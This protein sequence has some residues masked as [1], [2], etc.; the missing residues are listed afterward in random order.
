MAEMSLT[1]ILARLK[2]LKKR[3]PELIKNSTTIQLTKGEG[4]KKR[5]IGVSRS[6]NDTEIKLKVDHQKLMDLQDEFYRLNSR[7]LLANSTTFVE[8]SGDKMTIAE[9]VNKK[10]TIIY[11]KQH[12][13]RLRHEFVTLSNFIDKENDKLKADTDT[14]ILHAYGSD[15]KVEEAQYEA[16]A[17]P[18]RRDHFCK[19]LDPVG[20]EKAIEKLENEINGFEEE[21]DYVLSEVN[22]LTKIEV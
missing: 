19:L 6:I 17:E 8:V 18:R 10:N 5:L 2:V 1:R 3:I 7:L 11:K 12:L 16:I 22:A 4:V 20:I 9:A 21:I 13:A 14:A 15:T